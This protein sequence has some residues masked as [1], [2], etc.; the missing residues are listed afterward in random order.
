M[1]NPSILPRVLMLVGGRLR[2]LPNGTP[3]GGAAR[4]ALKLTAA[5][6]A[7]NVDARVLSIRRHRR[8]PKS[9]LIN[10][11]P[12]T[13]IDSLLWILN[14]KGVRRL[15]V[16]I[17]LFLLLSYLIR[18]RHTYDV[19]HVH[20]AAT[21][22]ALA[23]VLA[24]RW[25]GKPSI[26]KVTNSGKRNDIFRFRTGSGLPVANKLVRYLKHATCLIAL[27]PEATQDLLSEGFRPDQITHIPNGVEVDRIQP[28]QSY[29]L[30][31]AA[32][33]LYVGRLHSSK[34]IDVLL[35]ALALLN[36]QD[37]PW[38]LTLVGSGRERETLIR[39]TQELG[40]SDRVHFAGQTKDVNP[41]LQQVDV[42]V[43]P[44]QT[45]GI[46]NALLE[47][48]AVGLPCIVTDNP[49]NRRVFS[50]A[51][52]GLLVPV[53]DVSALATAVES[54]IKDSTLRERLGRAARHHVVTHF[55]INYVAATYKSLYSEI[56]TEA[57]EKRHARNSV[58]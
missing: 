34:K 42:F 4:Q 11:I 36:V 49:G 40:L 1:N 6:G 58:S 51:A 15:E 35:D 38:H 46:S 10:G 29:A 18:H 2:P 9:E 12:V 14:R 7:Q 47:A 43:L 13:Y 55:D 48:M 45:E 41:F 31:N 30:K 39:Q 25:M 17:R 21:V 44:S 50:D 52:V 3:I 27:N 22:T 32:H 33:I 37:C 5:F 56:I 23:G 28:R 54:L 26:L 53:D 57:R 24:G 20:T 19:I 8:T 16:L